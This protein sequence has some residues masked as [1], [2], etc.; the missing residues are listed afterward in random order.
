MTK[1][2]NSSVVALRLPDEWVVNLK[3][4]AKNRTRGNVSELLRPLIGN[5]VA[6]RSRGWAEFDT[7]RQEALEALKKRE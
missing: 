6:R 5:F 7:Q 4:L 3:R 1:G 2:R